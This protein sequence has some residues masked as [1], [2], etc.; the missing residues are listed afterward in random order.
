MFMGEQSFGAR[1]FI[2]SM[3]LQ[4]VSHVF[5]SNAPTLFESIPGFLNSDINVSIWSNFVLQVVLHLDSHGDDA[6]FEPGILWFA[7]V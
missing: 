4:V 3:L 7:Q 6:Q 5:P 1:G 2:I